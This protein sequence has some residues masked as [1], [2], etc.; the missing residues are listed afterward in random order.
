MTTTLYII[1]IIFFWLYFTNS[2]SI[3]QLS[4]TNIIKVIV[5]ILRPICFIKL[6][7]ICFFN[8]TMSLVENSV[9]LAI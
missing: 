8:N 3:F 7:I 4:S 9:S 6:N 2:H 1:I 5:F